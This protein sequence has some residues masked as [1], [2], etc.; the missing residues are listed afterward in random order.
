MKA[1]SRAIGFVLMALLAVAAPAS[2][3]AQ[4]ALLQGG[5][6]T[7]GHVPMYINSYSQQPVVTDSGPASG[8]GPGFGLGELGLTVRGTGT[9][10]YANAGTGPFGT[11]F[12]DYDAPVTNATGYHYICWS[13]N[14]QGGGL[15]AYGAGGTASVEPL[16]IAV[17]GT[18]YAFPPQNYPGGGVYYH[19]R[20]ITGT[21]TT[22]T[23]LYTDVV[24]NWNSTAAS[25][26]SEALPACST[27]NDGEV[28]IIKDE[29]QTSGL[30][31][32]TMTPAS[33][34][35][36]KTSSFTAN[37]GSGSW[38][39]VCDGSITNWTVN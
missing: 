3:Y 1:A 16:Q 13:P 33:G 36:E 23:A 9:A 5:P 19:R 35:I 18:L 17:N 11:N 6:I 31:P 39:L 27:T 38:T 29:A 25:A 28:F 20:T 14:A 22:D 30:Y 12:C 2:V 37:V 32:I 26:K 34:T 24:I 21:T 8:G 4:S 10:P 7:A 15:I